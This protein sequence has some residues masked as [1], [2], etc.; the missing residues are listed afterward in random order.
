VVND[1]ISILFS[2]GTPLYLDCSPLYCSFQYWWCLTLT[3]LVPHSYPPKNDCSRNLGE[4][5]RTCSHNGHR[6]LGQEIISV[7]G[8]S[9]TEQRCEGLWARGNRGTRGSLEKSIPDELHERRRY[10]L[11]WDHAMM[12][13]TTRFRWGRG[14]VLRRRKGTRLPGSGLRNRI[15]EALTVPSK[16]ATGK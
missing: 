11:Y 15:G 16:P 1:Y 12:T 10:R 5:W 4:R 6:S 2:S 7:R 8:I 14:R 9:R 3:V 13:V